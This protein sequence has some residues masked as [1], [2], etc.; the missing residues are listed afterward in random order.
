MINLKQSD[1]KENIENL[2]KWEQR[3]LDALKTLLKARQEENG[4]TER[5]LSMIEHSQI[6]LHNLNDNLAEIEGR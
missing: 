3:N 1:M 4:P 2:I 6:N 5:L